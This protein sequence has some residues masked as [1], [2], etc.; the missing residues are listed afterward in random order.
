M[1]GMGVN[2]GKL[3]A[4]TNISLAWKLASLFRYFEFPWLHFLDSFFLLVE[5][6][7]LES[8]PTLKVGRLPSLSFEMWAFSWMIDPD[9]GS[10][11][12]LAYLNPVI[13]AASKQ[14]LAVVFD[15]FFFSYPY[16][17]TSSN[18][19]GSLSITRLYVRSVTRYLFNVDSFET[20]A[21]TSLISSY[22]FLNDKRCLFCFSDIFWTHN[23]TLQEILRLQWNCPL[24]CNATARLP[25]SAIAPPFLP[26]GLS[27][28]NSV[29][30]DT[31][32]RY[33]KSRLEYTFFIYILRVWCK[34]QNDY[35][36][37]DRRCTP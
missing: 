33:T 22:F 29:G 25:Q 21:S 2:N 24:C 14:I 30:R 27:S 10:P 9:I 31:K 18:T 34:N 11:L 16:F 35:H 6:S 23:L 8:L 3:K 37:Q 28:E 32:S 12:S 20:P 15:N 36:F 4:W 1:K 19:S 7:S 5:Q 17:F 13:A 26:S